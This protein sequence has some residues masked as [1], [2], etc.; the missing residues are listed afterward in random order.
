MAI[1]DVIDRIEAQIK[2]NVAAEFTAEDARWTDGTTLRLPDSALGYFRHEPTETMLQTVPIVAV[3]ARGTRSDP[4]LTKVEDDTH[5]VDVVYFET[6]T[7][8]ATLDK[9]VFRAT[10]AL[11]RLARKFFNGGVVGA[12]RDWSGIIKTDIDRVEYLEPV[13]GREGPTAKGGLLRVLC[14]ERVT[15]L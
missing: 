1:E 6:D 7:T 13:V 8:R 2:A 11:R 14:R 15:G 10:Y 4:L 9:R 5:E 12:P 3:I